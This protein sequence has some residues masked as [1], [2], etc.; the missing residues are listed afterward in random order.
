M[1]EEQATEEQV[2]QPKEAPKA[3]TFTKEE[4]EEIVGKRIA[5]VRR[6][7]DRKFDGVNPDEYRQ[8]KAKEEADE[9]ER[10]KERGDFETVLKQTVEKWESK[11]SGLQNE[12]RR[13]KVDGALIS[14]ASQRKAIN[15]EQV[16]NLLRD[17]VRMSEDGT[18]EVVDVE[19]TARYSEQGI[20]MGVDALVDE[21]L[22]TNPHFVSATPSGTGAQSSVGG[23]IQQAKNIMDMN[24]EEYKEWRKSNRDQTRRY[25][26]PIPQG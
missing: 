9:V 24:H 22:N 10:Q 8:I 5:K 3:D 21:F 16:A 26:A 25:I 14:S 18:V 12:L 15:A 19:G 23:G 1:A 13:V 20:A 7:F 17:H 6:E 11:A 4:V 2:E